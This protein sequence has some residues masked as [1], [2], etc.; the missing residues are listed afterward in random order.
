MVP[1]PVPGDKTTILRPE[2]I[3]FYKGFWKKVDKDS[4]LAVVLQ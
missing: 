3:V 2:Y 1:V 4:K